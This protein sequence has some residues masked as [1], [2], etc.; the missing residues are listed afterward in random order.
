MSLEPS[1]RAP[2]NRP[3][4][5]ARPRELCSVSGGGG[6]S[7][8]NSGEH[9][10]L[11][12]QWQCRP[13]AVPSRLWLCGFIQRPERRE[14]PPKSRSAVLHTFLRSPRQRYLTQYVSTNYRPYSASM[15]LVAKRTLEL[16]LPMMPHYLQSPPSAPSALCLLLFPLMARHI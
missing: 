6:V 7:T 9:R 14:R 2:R 12:A 3:E 8:D 10:L 15:A 4:T 1:S 16:T 13:T 11:S 5:D